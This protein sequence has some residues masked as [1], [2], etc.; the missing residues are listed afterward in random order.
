MLD[1]NRL[2]IPSGTPEEVAAKRLQI[3]V[4]RGRLRISRVMS[5]I[6]RLTPKDYLL[7]I[8]STSFGVSPTG[9]L[10][11]SFFVNNTD[12]VSLNVNIFALAQLATLVDMPP[13]WAKKLLEKYKDEDYYGP[14][15]LAGDLQ[16]LL[17]ID[18]E[19]YLVR[20][21]DGEVRGVLSSRYKR[22]DSK[23]LIDAFAEVCMS[24]GAV[25]CDGTLTPTKVV[26]HAILPKIQHPIEGES[27]VYGVT[28]TNSDFGD[29]AMNVQ[30]Y[31]LRLEG[32]T[33]MIGKSGLRKVHRGK[34]LQEDINWSDETKEADI[35]L[36]Q[37][38][39]RDLVKSFLSQE[40]IDEAQMAIR[41][42]HGV[43]MGDDDVVTAYLKKFL[44]K[45]EIEEL[46]AKY[47]QPN[48]VELP[49]GNNA[50]RLVN[51]VA[52]LADQR[53][54]VD[55]TRALELRTASGQLMQEITL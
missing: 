30:M 25:P 28:F 50:W 16:T 32:G 21:V 37:A 27:V 1:V 46:L 49:P 52:W 35:K 17:M 4:E 7:K 12:E 33:G 15:L 55:E 10:L 41:R 36:A 48:A 11:M 8:A 3:I 23:P 9:R 47:N 38:Q 13:S 44:N 14:Q 29:G 54:E 51:A 43:P 39:V 6:E 20:V 5:L 45:T 18:P 2:T 31:M 40:K 42:A 26:V 53:E 34:E 22:L 24:V 19:R